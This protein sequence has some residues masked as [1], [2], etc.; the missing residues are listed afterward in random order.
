MV[1]SPHFGSNPLSDQWSRILMGEG[2]AL[3]QSIAAA[4]TGRIHQRNSETI[5]DE[6]KTKTHSNLT[7]DPFMAAT[8]A[9][10]VPIL[11]M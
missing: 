7:N 8:T 5:V 1:L 2:A 10:V 6:K 11:S 3:L 9:L 4:R